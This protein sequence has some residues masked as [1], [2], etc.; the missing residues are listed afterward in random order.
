M[1]NENHWVNRNVLIISTTQQR[2]SISVVVNIKSI[3][4][5]HKEKETNIDSCVSFF[6]FCRMNAQRSSDTCHFDLSA[7]IFVPSKKQFDPFEVNEANDDPE[8]DELSH[9]YLNSNLLDDEPPMTTTTTTT[10]PATIPTTTKGGNNLFMWQQDDWKSAQKVENIWKQDKL[11]PSVWDSFEPYSRGNEQEF[12]P[13]L[14]FYHG[15]LYDA[16]TI[17]DMN[18][19]KDNCPSAEETQ[20]ENV[21]E[22]M[23][24]LQMLQTIFSD[25]SE[26]KLI[27]TLEKNDYDVDRAIE[28]LLSN[29][30][31]VKPSNHDTKKRQVCRHFLAGECYRKDCWFVHD[32]QEKVCKFWLQGGCLK[33]EL[34][35]FSHNIDIQEVVANK[36][37]SSKQSE[38]KNDRTNVLNPNDYPA[39]GA[40]AKQTSVKSQSANVVAEEEFPSLAAAN[41]IKKSTPPQPVTKTI[42]FAEI[43]K[44]KANTPAGTVKKKQAT[45]HP[46]QKLSLQKLKQPVRIPWLETGSSLNSIYMKEVS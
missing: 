29:T 3:K 15:A 46:Y 24:T 20:V 25:L 44:K 28:A 35:E 37:N 38:V 40:S 23:T 22:D 32:L 34:C 11:S 14:H 19:L 10:I 16:S 41:K 30:T 27:D 43:A 12:D 39:L 33:G 1:P 42:N 9:H 31:N 26:Q 21:G 4:V 45:P 6:K 7:K 8:M 17:E 18:L 13:T 36:I 2:A 5:T